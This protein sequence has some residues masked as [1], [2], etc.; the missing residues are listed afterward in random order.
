MLKD[1]SMDPMAAALLKKFCKIASALLHTPVTSMA[2]VLF[3]V[4]LKFSGFF[5]EYKNEFLIFFIQ[6]IEKMVPI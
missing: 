6:E 5:K 2:G 3:L 4:W 1:P